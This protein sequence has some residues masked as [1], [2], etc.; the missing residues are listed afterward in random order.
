TLAQIYAFIKKFQENKIILAHW[1]GGIFFYNLMKKD[2]HETLKN[3]FFD[4][5]ASPF[6]YRPDIYEAAIKYAGIEKILFGSDFPLLKPDRYFKE[7]EQTELTHEDID[8]I[9]GLNAVN[10]F[11]L[12]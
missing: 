8:K 5:A 2:V 7:L 3:I 9:K 10:L 11:G 12:A 6:L 4:T 1:G